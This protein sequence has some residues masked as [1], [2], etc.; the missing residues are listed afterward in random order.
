MA[1]PGSTLADLQNRIITETNRDDLGDVLA[2]QLNQSIADAIS[3]Y[4]N[5]RFWF[6][7]LRLTTTIASG[8]QYTALPTG[9]ELIDDVYIVVGGVNFW[10]QKKTNDYLESLY[11]IPQIGQPIYWAPYLT[12]ARVWPTPNTNYPAIWLTVSDVTPALTYGPVPDTLNQSNNWTTDGMRLITAKAKHFLYRDV[13]KDADA[14][15]AA[16]DAV[17]AAY[18]NMK[19]I[20]NRRLSTGFVRAAW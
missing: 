16:M 5:E 4:G 17:E 18:A 11:T 12:Q 7:E 6:N 15:T 20:T 9:Y 1:V 2:N 13:F 3:D 10:L 19:G 8:S 14:A